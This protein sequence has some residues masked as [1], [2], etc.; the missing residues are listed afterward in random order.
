MSV[1]NLPEL[2]RDSEL[3]VTF[4]ETEENGLVTLHARPLGY[5]NSSE[6]Q[7][8][9]YEKTIGYG[10]AGLVLLQ[11]K[12][13]GPGIERMAVKQMKLTAGTDLTSDNPVSRR[14]V[15]EL[16][17]LAKFAQEKV[18]YKRV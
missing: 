9:R 2:V 17:A 4:E 12:T 7:R 5:R 15:R 1:S 13:C 8:W 18:R 10:G 14:Y 11:R 6:D 3:K 16:D